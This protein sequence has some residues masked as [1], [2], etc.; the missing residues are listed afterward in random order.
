M[1][2]R[3]LRDLLIPSP[4]SNPPVPSDPPGDFSE[5]ALIGEA[6]VFKGEVSGTQD[7]TVNGRFEGTVS[8]SG[9]TVTVGRNGRVQGDILARVIR[10]E[11]H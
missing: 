2:R 9:H 11:G 8:L 5:H 10:I 6:L 4:D 7:L 3:K 1:W